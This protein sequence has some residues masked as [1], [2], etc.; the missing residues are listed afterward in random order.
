MSLNP[1]DITGQGFEPVQIAMQ[2]AIMPLAQKA[3]QQQENNINSRNDEVLMQ[4]LREQQ[5]GL[6]RN[7]S[8]AQMAA[9]N[10]STAFKNQQLQA[11][12]QNANLQ[13]NV[14]PSVNQDLNQATAKALGKAQSPD[15]IP[16]LIMQNLQNPDLA[17]KYTDPNQFRNLS[18]N[19]QSQFGQ[20]QMGQQFNAYHTAVRNTISSGLEH[21]ILPGSFYTGQDPEAVTRLN[22]GQATPADLSSIDMSR[23]GGAV[24]AATNMRQ[25]LYQSRQLIAERNDLTKQ[26]LQESDPNVKAQ[27][28]A[29][30]NDIDSYTNAQH[31]SV[32]NP[33]IGAL[34]S[35]STLPPKLNASM[36]HSGAIDWKSKISN[37]PPDMP[38]FQGPDGKT[39][40]NPNY[41]A[42][43][44]VPTNPPPASAIA[45]TSSDDQSPLPVQ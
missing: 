28:Q 41:S 27:L 20:T 16:S 21:G 23:F 29:R 1:F 44:S 12:Q 43:K 13:Y 26:I 2:N 32:A 7:Q 18:A 24:S 30:I 6:Q 36:T 42:T 10:A 35:T 14:L 11:A 15:E 17:L 5:M 33:N 34:S 19:A 39:Y 37:L 38:T 9:I 22:T 4:S 8:M 31:S 3:V 25:A 45:S 40:K